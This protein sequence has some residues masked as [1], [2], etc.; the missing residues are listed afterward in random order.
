M[1]V[2][3]HLECLGLVAVRTQTP[4]R[5]FC[6]TQP[7]SDACDHYDCFYRIGYTGVLYNRMA[8]TIL[9]KTEA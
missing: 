4:T 5:Y 9:T 8:M 6:L 7:N 2:A 1:P 3:P